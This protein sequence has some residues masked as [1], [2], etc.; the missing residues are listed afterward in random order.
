[1]EQQINVVKI[2]THLPKSRQRALMRDINDGALSREEIMRKYS[3]A[4]GTFYRYRSKAEGM[5]EPE[6]KETKVYNAVEFMDSFVNLLDVDKTTKNYIF[7]MS[8]VYEKTKEQIVQD[9]VAMALGTGM[10]SIHAK[11]KV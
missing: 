1:M 5:R 9:L 10:E 2:R 7:G 4:T 8:L 11:T 3:I 6:A